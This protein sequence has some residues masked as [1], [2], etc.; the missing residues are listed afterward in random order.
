MST[1]DFVDDIIYY[2]PSLPLRDSGFCMMVCISCSS[3]KLLI[4]QKM[5]DIFLFNS[6]KFPGDM[7]YLKFL[8]LAWVEPLQTHVEVLLN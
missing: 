8:N 1:V 4:E 7:T 6:G 3:F 5:E 2:F